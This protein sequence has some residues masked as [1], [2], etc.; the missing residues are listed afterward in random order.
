M[1]YLW[2]FLIM[3]F[4]LCV[5]T[6]LICHA[7]GERSVFKALQESE[8]EL[9]ETKHFLENANAVI[10]ANVQ[11]IEIVLYSVLTGIWVENKKFSNSFEALAWISTLDTVYDIRIRAIKPDGSFAAA[12][13]MVSR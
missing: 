8:A 11:D 1:E 3:A 7:I 4:I 10:S 13:I 9:S 6:G 5:V 2:V 12:Q